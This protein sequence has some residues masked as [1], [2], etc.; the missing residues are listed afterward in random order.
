MRPVQL[1]QDVLPVGEFKAHLAQV[2]QKLRDSDRP[3][4]ITQNGRPAAVIVSPK[5]FDRL[6]E[7]ER[8]VDAIRAGLSD[9][10]A[11]RVIS[12]EVLDRQLTEE[13]GPEK[14]GRK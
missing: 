12:D 1:S 14:K 7:R 4:V 2:L 6:Q 11:G 8:F 13:F 9:A 3:V 5:E 10:E